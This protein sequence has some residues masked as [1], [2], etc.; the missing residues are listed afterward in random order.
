[1]SF[2]G[3]SPDAAAGAGVSTRNSRRGRCVRS[4]GG[5]TEDEADALALWVYAE[6]VLCRSAR[7]A[8]PLFAL[9]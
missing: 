6:A 9:R 4:T 3:T 2:A 8:G 7:S 5:V 1:M